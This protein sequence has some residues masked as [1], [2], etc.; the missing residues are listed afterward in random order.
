MCHKCELTKRS[1]KVAQR[2][3]NSAFWD[4]VSKMGSMNG[5]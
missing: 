2:F 4:I 1:T 3:W 5:R